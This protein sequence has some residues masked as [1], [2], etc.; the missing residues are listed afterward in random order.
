[1]REA[2]DAGIAGVAGAAPSETNKGDFDTLKTE[3]LAAQSQVM[4]KI[5]ALESKLGGDDTNQKENPP[6]AA[7]STEQPA[8]ETTALIEEL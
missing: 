3:M 5:G 8:A 6:V 2:L 7:A 1:M 4:E